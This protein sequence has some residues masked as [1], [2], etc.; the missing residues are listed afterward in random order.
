MKQEYAEIQMT[1]ERDDDEFDVT[2]CANWYPGLAAQ[3]YGPWENRYPEEPASIEILDVFGPNGEKHELSEKELLQAEEL[4]N[5][6]I[7]DRD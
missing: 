7:A 3:L 4:I 1:I 5:E 2:I 6:E